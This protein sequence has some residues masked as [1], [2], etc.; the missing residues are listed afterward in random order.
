MPEGKEII[1]SDNIVV[2][3][4]GLYDP[5][6][7]PADEDDDT[8]EQYKSVATTASIISET[9]LNNIPLGR[10]GAGKVLLS[11]EENIKMFVK[12]Q[13]AKDKGNGLPN[14]EVGVWVH[15]LTKGIEQDF[16]R[17]WTE[18]PVSIRPKLTG[19]AKKA[20]QGK[21]VISKQEK[22]D[23]IAQL[24]WGYWEPKVKSG[25]LSQEQ[26]FTKFQEAIAK[27]EEYEQLGAVINDKKTASIGEYDGEKSVVEAYSGEWDALDIYSKYGIKI[28]VPD[29]IENMFAS[30]TPPNKKVLGKLMKGGGALKIVYMCIAAY[31]KM[32]INKVDYG[33]PT[34][35]PVHSKFDEMM[36]RRNE[37]TSVVMDVNELL[38]E[39]P[40]LASNINKIENFE[41][42]GIHTGTYRKIHGTENVVIVDGINKVLNKRILFIAD[43]SD[44]V[45]TIYD[46]EWFNAEQQDQEVK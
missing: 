46:D 4:Q 34:F 36:D 6:L 38:N 24:S 31:Y 8:L 7:Q 27:K 30:K 26:A 12:D 22:N 13:L 2:G 10:G 32:K 21:R 5:T 23:L 20:K 35:R 14:S 11:V 29:I 41:F 19:L 28:I 43:G 18:P 44:A 37:R 3:H 16:K 25:A 17:T 39:L 15:Y 40:A 42:R 45:S 1:P 9:I 33:T